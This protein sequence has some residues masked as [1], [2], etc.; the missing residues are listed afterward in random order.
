MTAARWLTR[1]ADG[2]VL[3]VRVQP[4]ASRD[5][6]AGPHG[7]CLKVRIAAPPVDG[8]ANAQL[9]RYIAGLFRL[10]Q[11]SVSLLRGTSSRNKLVRVSGADCLP[12]E[13]SRWLD[14]D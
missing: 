8:A 6:I 2:I 3:T 4:R 1:D 11:A 10:P 13:L 5:A 14:P 12:L 7:D 9:C